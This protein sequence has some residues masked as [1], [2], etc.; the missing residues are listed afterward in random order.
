LDKGILI[1]DEDCFSRVCS[2]LLMSEGY[3]IET[4]SSVNDLAGR[5]DNE[6]FKLIIT[7]YP[8][9][10]FLFSDLKLRGLP[11]IVLSDHINIDFINN[12]EGFRNIFCMIKPIDYARF[13]S[14]VKDVM[15]G[16]VSVGGGY[17][18]V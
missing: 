9:G 13:R 5:L 6:E 10:A 17:C 8:Y 12:L 15:S 4:M 18:I 3:R 2:A 16:E 7:S 11:T 14:L 1:I